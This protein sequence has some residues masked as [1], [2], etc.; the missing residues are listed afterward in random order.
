MTLLKS[1]L[2]TLTLS[3]PTYAGWS[4]YKVP[5]ANKLVEQIGA[6]AQEELDP[7][8][9]SI[10]VWNMY[11]GQKKSWSKDFQELSDNRDILILQ[12]M[13]L[14]QK[15]RSSF[16]ENSEMEY[17][18]GT[19]FIY[20]REK[21]KTG[22]AT[23]SKAKAIKV[24]ARPSKILEPITETP[25][26][27]LMTEYALKNRDDS[28]LVIN[29]HAI[30]FVLPIDLKT[31]LDDLATFIKS[32]RGPVIFAGDFNAWSPAKKRILFNVTRKLELKAINF[33]EKDYRTKTFGYALDY[34]FVR[35]MSYDNSK[36]WGHIYGSDHKAL[37][38]DLKAHSIP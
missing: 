13:Y 6:S 5:K 3:A 7:D 20:A 16:L 37:T 30:N 31:Q 25:K 27:A 38:V 15:M 14:N 4:N 24:I 12:E 23:G 1:I 36:V 2:L 11:K 35:N 32:H 17:Q 18:T 33:G 9:I 19:N 10:L 29:I 22:V 26:M 34:I 21:V 8:H 28:L